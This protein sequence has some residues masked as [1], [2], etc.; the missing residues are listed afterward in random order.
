MQRG[1]NNMA[2]VN[3][4]TLEKSLTKEQFNGAK[5]SFMESLSYGF[6]GFGTN[7]LANM[8]ASFVTFYYTN[9]VAPRRRSSA[10]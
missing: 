7:I 3:N 5:L 4:P 8:I 10:P 2:S 6:T 1:E 9:S